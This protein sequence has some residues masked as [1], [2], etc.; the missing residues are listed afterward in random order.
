MVTDRVSGQGD[1]TENAKVTISRLAIVKALAGFLL[2]NLVLML[3]LQAAS[4]PPSPR[5]SVEALFLSGLMV[6]SGL[7]PTFKRR[8][9]AILLAIVVL[10]VLLLKLA[11]AAVRLAL[12][13]P[14]N[15]ALDWVLLSSV[16]DLSLGTFGNVV[17]TL[18]CLVGVAAILGT[19]W[20]LVRCMA[21]MSAIAV[22][23]HPS[24][25][26][27][28]GVVLAVLG[29]VLSLNVWPGWTKASL[30]G[31]GNRAVVEQARMAVRTYR[32]QQEFRL[33][34]AQDDLRTDEY[35]IP[36]LTDIDVLLIFVESYGA[37]ALEAEPFAS[38]IEPRLRSI[39]RDLDSA[40]IDMASAWLRSPTA[41]GQSWLAHGS[42]LSGLW[43]DNNAKYQALAI[44]ERRTLIDLFERTGHRSV[45][46]M[47]AI[48]WPWPEGEALGYDQV[49]KAVDLNYQGTP[50]NWVTMPD[51]FTLSAF[52]RMERSLP[53]SDRKPV[54]AKIAL[55]SSHAP[56]TP[57]AGL[58]DWADIDE[59]GM[60]FNDMATQG[61]SPAE[62]WSDPNL[63]RHHF[64]QALDYV[65]A[66]IGSYVER[67][68]DER[69][70]VIVMGDHQP[71]PIVTGPG[72][73]PKVPIH[74]FAKDN[75]LLGPFYEAG[76][77]DGLRPE[78]RGSIFPMSKF[79][80]QIV[81]GF[82]DLEG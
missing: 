34:M 67:F 70:L 75:L 1:R 14:L 11:I 18:V 39:E 36:G 47:P 33:E 10:A 5:L 17:G 25:T 55:I 38:V 12:D 19:F 35:S 45:A 26:L 59:G 23:W 3:P 62:V 16:F 49:Y 4:Y 15:L 22:D 51:Q 48:I 9:V 28:A 13:R 56:W 42:V 24:I 21:A 64:T 65:L 2:I 30:S 78:K 50:F 37:D 43:V 32:Q 60:I 44:G 79:R 40:G 80:N 20:L 63:V 72:A 46:V 69:T 54:F 58:V 31:I 74:V 81:R 76:Y 41:G 82:T 57:I 61:P 68:V 66:V 71:A 27:S 52:Q 7:L 8:L 6:I 77:R 53:Q 73:S 29:S